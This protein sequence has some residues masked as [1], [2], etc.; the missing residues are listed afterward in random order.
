MSFNVNLPEKYVIKKEIGS[1][2]MAR[3]FLAEDREL[4]KY[5]AVKVLNLD[6]ST[7]TS[8][9]QRFK[10]EMRLVQYI[11]S[12]YIVR[13]Y[14]GKYDKN[15]KYL[16]MEYVQGKMLK[17]VIEMQGRLQPDRAVDYA[18]QIAKGFSEIH[19]Q[20]IVHRDL[21]TS[22][23]MITNTG[24]VKIIDFGIAISD[25]SSRFTQTGKVIG[26]VH[27]LAPELIDKQEASPQ[28]DIYALGIIL[29]EMLIG[30]PP[31]RG[32]TPIETA[33]KHKTEPIPQVNKIYPNIPQALSNIV[34][35]ATAKKKE[36]RYQSMRQLEADLADCLSQKRM[37][38]KPIVLDDKPTI[39]RFGLFSRRK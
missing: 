7:P 31:H 24:Q 30:N 3:V 11:K 2:G 1:G 35:K 9:Q 28:S 21:K 8:N 19:A 33:L 27:Y 20:N 13:F 12:P 39:K 37:T 36:L 14:E 6:P 10:E 17:E 26:S 34:V 32:K 18:I 38:E 22:N 5:V 29:Y 15:I 25:D 16:S 4:G 23:V